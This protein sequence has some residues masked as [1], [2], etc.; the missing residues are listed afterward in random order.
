ML[1]GKPVLELTRHHSPV[2][3]VVSRT[4]KVNPPLFKYMQI[5]CNWYSEIHCKSKRFRLTGKLWIFSKIYF[6][7]TPATATVFK[8]FYSST[9]HKYFPLHFD[10]QTF[11]RINLKHLIASIQHHQ[12]LENASIMN[13]LF[14]PHH[15]NEHRLLLVL[16]KCA[17]WPTPTD[18]RMRA[19]TV[20][21]WKKSDWQLLLELK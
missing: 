12:S 6:G 20:G 14:E 10:F 17:G 13:T 3:S 5:F 16:D 1:E 11:F 2:P 18:F 21:I 15:T 7:V 8:L 19:H 4:L 9:I